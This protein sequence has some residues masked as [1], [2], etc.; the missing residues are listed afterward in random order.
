MYTT[1]LFVFCLI[2]E[3]KIGFRYLLF[4]FDSVGFVS[5]VLVSK[6]GKGFYVR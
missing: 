1:C 2:N 4:E 3:N 5:L 6:L